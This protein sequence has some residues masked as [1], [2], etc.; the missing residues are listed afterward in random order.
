MG[1]FTAEQF[2]SCINF[3]LNQWITDSEEMVGEETDF[4]T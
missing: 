2:E 1:L 4:K 3:F